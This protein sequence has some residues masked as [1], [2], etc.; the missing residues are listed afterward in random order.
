M[1]RSVSKLFDEYQELTSQA[2]NPSEYLVLKHDQNEFPNLPVNPN[3]L[4]LS[5]KNMR[6]RYF[7]ILYI[8]PNTFSISK[9][10]SYNLLNFYLYFSLIMIFNLVLSIFLFQDSKISSNFF[11]YHIVCTS[12][13]LSFGYFFLL[14]LQKSHRAIL[15]NRRF[16][17]VFGFLMY[18]YLI[19]G[20]SQVFE[21]IS[22]DSMGSHLIPTLVE[23]FG[24]TYTYRRL[25]FD[26]YRCIGSTLIPVLILYLAINLIYSNVSVYTTLT[27]FCCFML[28]AVLQVAESHSV[29]NRTIQLFYRMEKEEQGVQDNNKKS[30]DSGCKEKNSTIESL[31]N[32]CEYVIT[33]I[34]HAI[35]V[36]IFRDV[37]DR[38][39]KARTELIK[40]KNKISSIEY[41]TDISQVANGLD[42]QDKAFIAE[43]YLKNSTLRIR[44]SSRTTKPDT[45]VINLR[46]DLNQSTLQQIENYLTKLGSEWNINPFY[47]EE[48]TG[49]TFSVISIYIF[50]IANLSETLKIPEDHFSSF[51]EVLEQVTLK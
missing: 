19:F 43:N 45:R 13:F 48:R 26:C 22:S 24:L 38:L 34:K 14:A 37:K 10:F 33:E 50:K 21:N 23:I 41:P 27:E 1:N 6:A 16:F 5:D 40:I 17:T 20:S 8:D 29:E 36:I 35:S 12:F 46:T 49:K 39:K 42:E 15:I 9:E 32:K 11:I 47:I 30:F 28:F 51:F 7:K 18:V 25:L 31:E 4:F 2:R 3:L 44:P